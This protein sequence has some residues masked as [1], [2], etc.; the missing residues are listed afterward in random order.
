MMQS[1]RYTTLLRTQK[2]TG[3]YIRHE[4]TGHPQ[5]SKPVSQTPQHGSYGNLLFDP[6]W[7]AKRAEIILRDNASCVVCRSGDELQVHH[8]QY[9]FVREVNGFRMPWAYPNHLLI[10]LCKS[11]HQRGHNKYKVPTLII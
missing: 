11:C 9:Q 5:Q 8:R 7:K 10:T 2:L 1:R 6:R 3:R 4:L